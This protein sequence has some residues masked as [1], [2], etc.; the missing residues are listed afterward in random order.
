TKNLYRREWQRGGVHVHDEPIRIEDDRE[1]LVVALVQKKVSEVIG[2]ERFNSSF[3]IG[4][5]ASFESFLET[6]GVK[7]AEIEIEPGIFDGPE[8]TENLSEREGVD[9]ADVNRIAK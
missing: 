4:M 2:S 3:Q 7:K 6:A 1:R 9:V 5:L 8:Q